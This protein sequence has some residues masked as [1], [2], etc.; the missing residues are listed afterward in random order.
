MLIRA[1]I[2]KEIATNALVGLVNLFIVLLKLTKRIKTNIAIPIGIKG[3]RIDIFMR[4]V[5]KNF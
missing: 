1:D 2:I 3:M 5:T 4:F